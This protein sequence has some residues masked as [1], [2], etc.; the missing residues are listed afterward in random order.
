MII[1]Y[2]FLSDAAAVNAA[3]ED[4]N[5]PVA[6]V[7]DRFLTVRYKPTEVTLQ[8]VDFDFGADTSI[9]C[10]CLSSNLTSLATITVQHDDNAAFT[11]P[12]TI[13]ITET[14]ETIFETFTAASDRYWRVNIS[15]ASLAEIQVGRLTLGNFYTMPDVSIRPTVE[16]GTTAQVR[17][18]NSGQAHGVSGYEY[19][20]YDVTFQ[21]P[22]N[23]QRKEVEA[24]FQSLKNYNPFFA[25]VFG[26]GTFPPAYVTI[27]QD[28]LSVTVQ[29]YGGYSF[30]LQLREVY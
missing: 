5:F 23:A 26:D 22:T 21:N 7:K 13:A 10:L 24:I 14:G 18:S 4:T 27:D 6:N 25:D 2:E 30:N 9:S 1:A 20:I 12:T 19:R 28:S 29:S 8:H 11:S 3:T 17:F 16:Y 15:D